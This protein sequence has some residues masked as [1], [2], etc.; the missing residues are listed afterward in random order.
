M[1]PFDRAHRTLPAT[2]GVIALATVVLL[3][4]WDVHPRLFPPGAH[5]LLGAL[6]LAL[7]AFAH[8][9]H[10]LERRPACLEVV[11]AIMLAAAFLFWA[12]NQLWPEIPPATLFN[13][14]AIGLFVLDV[15]LVIVGR[16]ASSL[17]AS[18]AEITPERNGRGA[19][20]T[21]RPGR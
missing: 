14:I 6:P 18:F 15:F 10:Q 1:R 19:S 13:D 4:T 2:L 8:L 20:E 7:I 3:L 9:A 5:D 21:G 11:K 17:D 12:A 16:P